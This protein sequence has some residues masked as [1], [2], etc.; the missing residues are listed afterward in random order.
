MK[1]KTVK[2]VKKEMFRAEITA[3][4]GGANEKVYD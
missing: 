1:G 2:T 3:L 4:K